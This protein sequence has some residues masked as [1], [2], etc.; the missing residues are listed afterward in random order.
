[1]DATDDDVRAFI[2][3][4]ASPVRRRDA[5]T[6]L[7]L[8]G[9]VTGETPRMWGPTIV[10]FGAYHYRYA[11]GR[12]GDAPAA[13]FSPRKAATT[14]YLPDGVDAHET[15]LDRLGEHTTGV[16]C[17]YLKDLD[18]VDPGVLERILVASYRRVTSGSFGRSSAGPGRST[19]G[20]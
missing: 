11:T 14:I 4:V 7:A 3:R 5:E 18:R 2:E 8:L 12:E 1:M 15:E 13:S 6:L 19:V 9:R 20:Q 16:G 17:L 10:G